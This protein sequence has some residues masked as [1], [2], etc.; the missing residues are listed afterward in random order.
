[1]DA[2]LQ[3]PRAGLAPFSGATK[4]AQFDARD[5]LDRGR[6]GLRALVPFAGPAIIASVSYMD[7]NCSG[8]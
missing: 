2:L 4:Q 7:T 6:T 5:V 3:R 1:M 8:W